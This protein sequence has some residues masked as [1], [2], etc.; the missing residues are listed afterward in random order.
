VESEAA[1]E[2]ERERRRLLP[3]RKS[4]RQREGCLRVMAGPPV[5]REEGTGV[6]VGNR[7]MV[8]KL[9]VVRWERCKVGWRI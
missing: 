7:R 5:S 4:F 3:V 6:A 1:E 8:V 9:G 2:R